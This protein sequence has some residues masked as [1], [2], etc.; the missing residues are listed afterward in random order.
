MNESPIEAVMN[1]YE[2]ALTVQIPEETPDP[3]PPSRVTARVDS[4]WFEANERGVTFLGSF[5]SAS[6]TDSTFVGNAAMHAGGGLL[7][8]ILTTDPAVNVTGCRFVGNAA[9]YVNIDAFA[10]YADEFRV[11]DDEVNRAVCF[12]PVRA[13]SF[14]NMGGYTDGCGM[15][16]YN[17]PSFWSPQEYNDNRFSLS[18]HPLR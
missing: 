8:H 17:F 9:G 10:A 5:A 15:W 2:A 1:L 4:S 12:R 11:H 16:M 6:V 18:S 14:H 7:I 3:Y 13:K